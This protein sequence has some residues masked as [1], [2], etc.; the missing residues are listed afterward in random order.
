MEIIV[1][2]RGTGRTLELIKKSN[3]TGGYI[4]CM[5][6][7]ESERILSHSQEL[8][9]NIP[10]PIT[11]EEFI[12]KRYHSK[13]IKNFLIDNVEDLLQ[14]LTDV[15]IDAI[16]LAEQEN[17]IAEEDNVSNDDDDSSLPWNFRK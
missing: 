11:Y 10:M 14:T 7:K 4:V 5:S 1:K 3:K 6:Q 2:K 12:N 9:L 16:T 13:G 8:G 15:K 17:L